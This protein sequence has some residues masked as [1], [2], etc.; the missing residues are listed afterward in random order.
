MSG[1]ASIGGGIFYFNMTKPFKD[2]Q[3]AGKKC[4]MIYKS[5]KDYDRKDE[6]KKLRNILNHIKQKIIKNQLKIN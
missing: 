1:L 4:P 3:G 2:Y 6:K 5:K